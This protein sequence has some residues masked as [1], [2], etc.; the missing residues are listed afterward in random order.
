M[1]MFLA[2]G[3]VELLVMAGYAPGNYQLALGFAIPND[4]I[5]PLRTE[6]DGEDRLG[7]RDETRDVL[8][9]HLK[10]AYWQITRS[11]PDGE[12]AVWDVQIGVV[13]PQA[14]TVGTLLAYTRS[15][16]GKVVT[17]LEGVTV[18]DIGGGDLQRIEC[19]IS[20]YQI[21][22]RRLGEGTIR[23]AR[24]LREKFPQL[25]LR[26]VAAQR[27]LVSQRLM[28]AG[29]TRDIS[30]QVQEA[31]ASQGQAILADLLPSLRQSHR[32]V[33]ITGG[34]VILLHATIAE[35]LALEPKRQGEDYDLVPPEFA[36]V[37]NAV[38]VLFAVVLKAAKK[39]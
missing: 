5:V 36:S 26:D 8:L 29:R 20:P 31:I 37:L 30:G 9:T 7:V 11:S 1:R 10:G 23:I 12:S 34:G 22:A 4:E 19:T 13:L 27:A 17:D 14:Q 18:I 25:E 3:V 24:A 32:F 2:A 21:V 35:R 6:A 28:V 38:A 16:S 15:A 33:I 39:R